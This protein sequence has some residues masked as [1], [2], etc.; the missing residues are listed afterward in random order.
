MMDGYNIVII[1]TFNCS[2]D[3]SFE[4]CYIAAV[5]IETAFQDWLVGMTQ[6]AE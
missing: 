6:I 3:K 5:E 1:F 4:R 2:F